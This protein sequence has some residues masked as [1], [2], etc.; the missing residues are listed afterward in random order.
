MVADEP[1]VVSRDTASRGQLIKPVLFGFGRHG[2]KDI[3]ANG[4]CI[5]IFAF[6][7]CEHTVIHKGSHL[8]PLVPLCYDEAVAN[9]LFPD[10]RLLF[11]CDGP[12]VGAQVCA[13]MTRNATADP[14]PGTVR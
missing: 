11:A 1:C 8:V 14:F 13:T 7:T 2:K 3:S 9:L 12:S 5:F 6:M 10:H 4:L